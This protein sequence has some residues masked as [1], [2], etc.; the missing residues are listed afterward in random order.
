MK[1]RRHTH[2]ARNRIHCDEKG[3]MY[4]KVGTARIYL[5]EETVKEIEATVQDA[6][7]YA[8]LRR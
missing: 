7:L 6:V 3:R 4:W 1:K 5:E 2:L 8:S